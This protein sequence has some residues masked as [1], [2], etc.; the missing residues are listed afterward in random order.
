MSLMAISVAHGGPLAASEVL[1][2]QKADQLSTSE[3]VKTAR[4]SRSIGAAQ[5]LSLP[6]RRPQRRRSPDTPKPRLS[7]QHAFWPRI[8]ENRRKAGDA[9]RFSRVGGLGID[10]FDNELLTMYTY[11]P[12]YSG[13]SKRTISGRR[14]PWL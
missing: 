11:L 1:S 2:P 7:R 3:Y 9:T 6:G 13:S 10:R 12:M 8:E 4:Y 14:S 5:A